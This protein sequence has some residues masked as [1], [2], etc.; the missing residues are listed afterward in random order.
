MSKEEEHPS[1]RP[2]S[3]SL[4]SLSQSDGS[5]DPN[6]DSEEYQIGLR[7]TPASKLYPEFQNIDTSGYVRPPKTVFKDMLPEERRGLLAR[8]L[9]IDS[10]AST[11]NTEA[12]QILLPDRSEK[13]SKNNINKRRK[14]LEEIS[15]LKEKHSDKFNENIPSVVFNGRVLQKYFEVTDPYAK[16]E[17]TSDSFSTERKLITIS[18]ELSTYLAEELWRVNPEDIEDKFL[19]LLGIVDD[20]TV[21]DKKTSF[22]SNAS[23]I[24]KSVKMSAVVGDKAGIFTIPNLKFLEKNKLLDSTIKKTVN[25]INEKRS[26]ICGRTQVFIDS[27][28]S[29][30]ND[31]AYKIWLSFMAVVAP[32]RASE[33]GGR[34]TRRNKRN[35]QNKS[36][37]GKQSSKRT[38]RRRR[39]NK[40][41]RTLRK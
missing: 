27:C 15:R 18:D 37:K 16:F 8:Q 23:P 7:T 14:I 21:P 11:L 9:S 13:R 33:T 30:I 3:G 34:R 35:K 24:N 20:G 5:Q 12:R 6:S 39:T 41:R 17:P 38:L 4:S 2:R 36:K 22:I 40:R 25:K 32:V 26:T 10:N 19:D 31:I 28:T 29:K 1:K